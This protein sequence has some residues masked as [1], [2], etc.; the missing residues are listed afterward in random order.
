MSVCGNQNRCIEFKDACACI[1]AQIHWNCR[2]TQ[3]RFSMHKANWLQFLSIKCI[4][5][6]EIKNI[7]KIL[8]IILVDIPYD[9]RIWIFN[10]S[11]DDSNNEDYCRFLNTI[12]HHVV[13]HLVWVCMCMC[14]CAYGCL[15]EFVQIWSAAIFITPFITFRF[16]S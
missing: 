12:G 13:L 3:N 15:L 2:V 11:T 6:T 1:C 7:W 8:A 14:M 4:F 9:R 5:A 10:H 16:L